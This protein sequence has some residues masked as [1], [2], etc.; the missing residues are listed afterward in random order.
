MLLLSGE[1]VDIYVVVQR[2]ISA[3]PFRITWSRHRSRLIVR[4]WEKAGQGLGKFPYKSVQHR[5]NLGFMNRWGV[6]TSERR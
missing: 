1:N 3:N 5:D 2:F 4:A 6:L